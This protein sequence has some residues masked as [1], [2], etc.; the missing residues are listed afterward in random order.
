MCP[1]TACRSNK[2]MRFPF[3]IV[4]LASLMVCG[5]SARVVNHKLSPQKAFEG[6]QINCMSYL[7]R[8]T[9]MAIWW[10]TRFDLFDPAPRN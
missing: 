7:Y 1:H 10:W 6:I 5:L 9:I 8:T 4:L 2:A 3:L